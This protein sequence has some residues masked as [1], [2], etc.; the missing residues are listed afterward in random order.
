MVRK[1]LLDVRK[2]DSC[3]MSQPFMGPFHLPLQPL[4]LSPFPFLSPVHTVALSHEPPSS[5]PS[6][7]SL[8]TA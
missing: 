6:E 8:P 2:E 3:C 1:I 4:F 5:A 7:T